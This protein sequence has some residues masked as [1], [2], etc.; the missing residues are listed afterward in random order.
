MAKTEVFA[1]I[2]GFTTNIVAR[3]D[4]PVCNLNITSQCEAVQRLAR[5]LTEV[6]PLQEISFKPHLPHTLQLG[7]EYCNHAACPVLAGIIKAIEVAGGLALPADAFI[8][9]EK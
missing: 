7:M 8:K 1:G 5:E 9:V 3:M 6:D 4:G 2:C